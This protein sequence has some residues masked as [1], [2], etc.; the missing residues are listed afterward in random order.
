MGARNNLCVAKKLPSSPPQALQKV[1]TL[2]YAYMNNAVNKRTIT[3]QSFFTFPVFPS[4]FVVK[5]RH[6]YGVSPGG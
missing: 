6:K 2:L 4:A 3:Q 5:S 1:Y